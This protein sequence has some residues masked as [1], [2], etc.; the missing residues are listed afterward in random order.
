MLRRCGRRWQAERRHRDWLGTPPLKRPLTSC[1]RTGRPLREPRLVFVIVGDGPEERD[2][3]G[4]PDAGVTTRFRFVDWIDHADVPAYLNARTSSC[5]DADRESGVDVL[6]AGLRA[7]AAG[8]D[9]RLLAKWSSMARRAAVPSGTWRMCIEA[10]AAAADPEL[11]RT[12]GSRAR[13]T[14]PPPRAGGRGRAMRRDRGLV[15][16]ARVPPNAKVMPLKQIAIVRYGRR[17]PI[18]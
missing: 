8:S 14:V 17:Q 16:D 3:G 10:R 2:E 5:H 12:I 15:G 9:I 6:E 7:P 11:R 18:R 13:A 4:M 1:S